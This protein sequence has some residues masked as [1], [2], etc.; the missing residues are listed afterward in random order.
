V[1]VPLG[2]REVCGVVWDATAPPPDPSA[3]KSIVG[4]LEGLAPLPASW[5]EL[6]A[7][8]AGYYQRSLGEVA[9]AA[10]PPQLRELDA[11]Q[12]ARRLKR[13][14]PDA[15]AGHAA[16]R[17]ELT[18]DQAAALWRPTPR[19]TPRAGRAARA[20]G[21]PAQVATHCDSSAVRPPCC[22]RA[23]ARGPGPAAS[24]V[25]QLRRGA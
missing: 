3:L 12:L 13:A 18:A 7:F 1:R 2:R 14:T 4:P 21:F 5:R 6:V 10:L 22:G 23:W 9:L 15:Q 25:V 19:R 20:P 8:T 16:P 11:V 24:C 17:P